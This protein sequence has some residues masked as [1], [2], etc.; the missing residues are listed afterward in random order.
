MIFWRQKCTI[1]QHT[2]ARMHACTLIYICM[3]RYTDLSTPILIY[4]CVYTY[5][6]LHTN[7]YIL[8]NLYICTCI[9]IY[10]CIYKWYI[11]V[12]GCVCVC[13]GGWVGWCVCVRLCVCKSIQS[14]YMK[15][16][17]V[18]THTHTQSYT[19]PAHP[20]IYINLFLLDIISNSK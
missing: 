7:I 2:H 9:S 4:I 1:T 18:C 17:Y 10:I 13:V 6:C 19:S 20:Q 5:V 15:T 3:Y 8:T 16:L 11:S 12:C 14:F